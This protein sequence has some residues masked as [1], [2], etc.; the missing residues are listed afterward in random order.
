M[1]EAGSNIACVETF[2][3]DSLKRIKDFEFFLI[4]QR[5]AMSIAIA[6]PDKKKEIFCSPG[7][8]WTE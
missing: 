7:N 5:M 3:N 4:Q 6:T 8:R 2:K 1:T